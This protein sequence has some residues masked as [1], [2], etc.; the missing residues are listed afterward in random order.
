MKWS[1]IGLL[2]LGLIAATAAAILMSS[3]LRS[4]TVA[5][6]PGGIEETVMVASRELPAMTVVDSDCVETA[7]VPAGKSTSEFMYNRAEVIGRV[8]ARPMVKGQAFRSDCFVPS[9]AGSLLAAGLE[10]GKRAMSVSLADYSGIEG[11]LY[12]GCMVDVLVTFD[13][14]TSNGQTEPVSTTLLRNVR[15]LGI[16]AERKN[17]ETVSPATQERHIPVILSGSKRV[18]TLLVDSEQAG[19]LQLATE[20]GKIS[21]AMR[22][23]SDDAPVRSDMTVLRDLVKTVGS[24]PPVVAMAPAASSPAA[25]PERPQLTHW[26]TTVFHGATQE[27]REFSAPAGMRQIKE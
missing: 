10:K 17:Q 8:V 18:V 16:E 26:T 12:P 21:L 7:K 27:V 1:V 11:L 6:M 13:M 19:V 20:H 15:V 4:G 14:P 25:G 23:P 2:V 3:R 22:N 5:S 9:V 24:L